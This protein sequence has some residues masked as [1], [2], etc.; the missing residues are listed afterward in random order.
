MMIKDFSAGEHTAALWAQVRPTI[1]EI[2]ALPFLNRLA[3]GSLDARA[4]TNYILQD[5]LYLAHYARAMALLAAKAHSRAEARFWAGA[6]ATAIEVEEGMH[7]ALLADT[8][9]APERE[10]LLTGTDAP[11]PSPTTLG[12]VSWLIAIAATE[13]YALGV[14]GVLP[15]FWIYAHV[16]KVLVQRARALGEGHPYRTWVDTYDSEVFDASTRQA[17]AILESELVRA[18]A[19]ERARMAAVFAQACTYELHF[20]AMAH[21]LQ[22]WELSPGND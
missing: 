11:V 4:F 6:A 10:A 22:A 13:S 8:L 14:A 3:N 20:W 15:C 9:L 16:G 19:A 7:G 17:V 18:D 2:E 12:Y 21:R 5:G 1:T